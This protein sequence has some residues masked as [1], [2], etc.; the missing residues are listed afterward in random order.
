MF[1]AIDDTDSREGMCTTY[2]L[3]EIIRRS[4]LD[5]IGYP[6]LVRLNPAIEYK[7]RG[8]GALAVNL[9][10][11]IGGKRKIGEFGDTQIYGF[12]R[13]DESISEDA[14]LSLSVD[15]V[16][17]FAALDEENTNP[18]I[19][20][21]RNRFPE[22]FYWKAVREEVQA[23]TAR[24]FI[25]E[26]GGTCVGI[27][28]GRGIIGAAAALSWPGQDVTYELLSY[29][30]PSSDPVP[31]EVKMR[32]ASRSER[33][34]ST[35]NNL[36]ERNAYPAVFPKERTPV[37]MGI[38]GFLPDALVRGFP[39]AVSGERLSIGRFIVFR[40]NQG[41]DDHIIHDGRVL[42]DR[43]SYSIRGRILEKPQVIQG[44]HYFS[45][46]IADSGTVRI[47]AFEPTKEFRSTFGK[48]QPKDEVRVYGTYH[49]GCI[50]VEKLEV[51]SIS[52]H[53]SRTPPECRKCGVEMA[54][55]GYGDY[56]CRKCGS[57]SSV[58]HYEEKVRAIAPGRYDVPVIAR[59]HLSRAF[60]I[61]EIS[62]LQ[63]EAP[64]P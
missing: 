21:S 59:R 64:S 30:Y 27:K 34:P 4:G 16:K 18:G 2:L 38:R 6:E 58:P 51:L 47:A 24:E 40:T 5:V 19:V 53:F 41:T 48:L 29:R 39:E 26:N 54:S 33:I 1:V 10:R 56:R 36:D 57:R 45:T 9:G 31:P 49:D 23:G 11:G 35:F 25:G 13:G 61:G 17:E 52:A 50:N 44:S 14:L 20:V 3:T 42:V 37:V 32:I 63:E 7:T 55:K 46:M 62:H 22:W 8:N 12:D 43:Q 28:N 60:A 15:A